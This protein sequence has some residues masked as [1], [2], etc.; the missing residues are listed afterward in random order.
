MTS[1]KIG[2]YE[3]KSELG[4]G[5][6]AT[7][8][9]AYDPRFEREVALKVLPRE[10]LHD[11]QFKVRFER[12]AKT[13]A[14]LEHPSIVP[15][16]DFGEEDGQP[17]FVMRCMTGGS[18]ADMLEKGPLPLKEAAQ[19]MSRIAG[20]LDDAHIKGIV[21]RDLKPG[22]ILFDRGGEPYVSDFGIAKM[23]QSQGVTV[24][25]GAIIGTPAYMSPEQ[26]QGEKVDGR[27]DVYALGVILFEMLSGQQPYQATTPMAVVVKHITDPIPH[28]LDVR[29]DLPVDVERIIE[30]AMAKN[31]DE[32]FATAGEFA[33][34]LNAVAEGQRADDAL[35]TAAMSTRE[36]AQKTRIARQKML[37]EATVAGKPA[38]AMASVPM[39]LWIGIAVVAV[40][41]LAAVGVGGFMLFGQPASP[42]PTA[43]SP[44]VAVSPT[45][46]QAPSS[47]VEAPTATSE[48]VE[49]TPTLEPT[50]EPITLPGNADKIAF[51]ANNEV[52]IMNADGSDLRQ[53]TNNGFPKSDLQWIPP[54]YTTLVFI[55]G[56]NI[57]TVDTANGDRFDTIASFPNAE[58]VEAFR[59]SP[60]GTQV[61]I[62]LNRE[63][64]V[65]P[66][67]VEQ[68]RALRGKT[69][70]I[71]M[72]GCINHTPNTQAGQAVKEIRWAD[73]GKTIA[74][75]FAGV[76]AGTSRAVDLVRVLDIS[77]CQAETINRLDEFPGTRFT[78][79]GYSSQPL[80]PDIDF[81]GSVLFLLNSSIR[82]SGWGHLYEY[83]T[84][85]RR[86]LQLDPFGPGT[87]CYRD[88]R[89]SPDKNY[90]IFAFQDRSLGPAAPT[91]VYYIP[92]TT[93]GLTTTFTPIP[94]P[95]GFFTNPREAPQFALRPPPAP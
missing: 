56:K 30:K 75:L 9:K 11:A 70:L 87:C 89:W 53:L 68:L 67:D 44:A 25:G 16:Y 43:T 71:A 51:I 37:D 26:A 88:A 17:Y 41:L 21:H 10:M 49:P 79:E 61:A 40:L 91:Q 45:E 57:N 65:V 20:G 85:A 90:I 81:D 62:S 52:W 77:T 74:V 15:V 54:A 8:Y 84:E 35:K 24:T 1:Q 95:E 69:G 39:G 48:A 14:L 59:M 31:V 60:D 55:S 3:I 42:E 7:V 36:I 46:E 82:N 78:M 23:T 38:T 5:G 6:M 32:R 73:D 50:P 2:R 13:I 18:L 33:S 12:E 86:A 83:N 34:A 22:N 94:L 63:M 19:I 80:I 76:E 66:F 72:E 64:Y 47:A 27:S 28:I 92:Y 4:R 58:F 93:I 29:S